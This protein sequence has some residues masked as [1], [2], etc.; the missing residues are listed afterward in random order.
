MNLARCLCVGKKKRQLLGKEHDCLGQPQ[1]AVYKH[2]MVSRITRVPLGIIG[3]EVED[4]TGAKEEPLG[5][6]IH[7]EITGKNNAAHGPD[8]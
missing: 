8:V 6:K 2:V 5:N 7:Q 4:K 1:P 3:P